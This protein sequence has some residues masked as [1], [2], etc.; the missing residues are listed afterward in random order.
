[1][2]RY[3]LLRGQ[4]LKLRLSL[5]FTFGLC[6]RTPNEVVGIAIRGFELLVHLL[7]NRHMVAVPSQRPWAPCAGQAFGQLFDHLIGMT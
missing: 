5:A 6:A 1:M 2:A 3:Q 7:H 4:T